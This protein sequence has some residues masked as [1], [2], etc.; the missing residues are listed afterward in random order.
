[1]LNSGMTSG[2]SL[3]SG[4]ESLSGQKVKHMVSTEMLSSSPLSFTG[5]DAFFGLGTGGVVIIPTRVKYSMF[6]AHFRCQGG[7]LGKLQVVHQS[8]I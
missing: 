8:E 2:A 7:L 3:G 1:M 4:S 6:W 5:S